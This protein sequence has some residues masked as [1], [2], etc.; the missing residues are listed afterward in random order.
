MYGMLRACAMCTPA[1]ALGLSMSNSL[2][3]HASHEVSRSWSNHGPN[4]SL[5]FDGGA[6]ALDPALTYREFHKAE[7]LHSSL[8]SAKKKETC[9]A[10]RAFVSFMRLSLDSH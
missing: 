4:W 2:S 3:L 9:L 1:M 7:N 5:F 6:L 10:S 8:H